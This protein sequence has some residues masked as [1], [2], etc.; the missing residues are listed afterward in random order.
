MEMILL[1]KR[2]IMKKTYLG[3]VVMILASISTLRAQ[4]IEY[5]I[6]EDNPD[7]IYSGFLSAGIGMIFNKQYN[8]LPLAIN[9]RYNLAALQVEG[10]VHYDLYK[11]EGEGTTFLTE[12]GAFLPFSSSDKTKDV[13]V[14][15]DYDPYADYNAATGERTETTTFFMAP[16]T[17]EL[18][19]GV[20]GGVYYQKSGAEG[21]GFSGTTFVNLGGVYLGYQQLA[22]AYINTRINDQFERAASSFSKWYVDIMILPVSSI[23]D[24]TINFETSK[25]GIIGW[26]AGLQLFGNAH[27]GA[28]GVFRRIIYSADI[29]SRPLTGFNYTFTA[30][31]PLVSFK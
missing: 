19:K 8:A 26:R 10:A 2:I 20:R 4:Q 24:E 13:K 14:I 16:A 28:K 3:I 11:L 18:Q 5:R 30:T 21:T 25:D 12:A 17:V 9:G 7:K 23:A 1:L 22:K 31:Y 27:E 6:I 15:T 29:G